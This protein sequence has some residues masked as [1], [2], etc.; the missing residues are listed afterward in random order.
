MLNL[1]YGFPSASS[2]L[3]SIICPISDIQVGHPILN[4]R[5]PDAGHDDG[6]LHQVVTAVRLFHGSFRSHSG[7]SSHGRR[8]RTCL[9]K[10]FPPSSS[11]SIPKL[12]Q[13]EQQFFWL[14]IDFSV[15]SL[16]LHRGISFLLQCPRWLLD[17]L[18]L[19]LLPSAAHYPTESHYETAVASILKAA[20]PPASNST[21]FW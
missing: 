7:R 16:S 17:S 3:I 8:R 20:P 15:G 11:S 1:G 10:I 6:Q 9:E 13:A 21:T 18:A 12:L 2:R 5:S 14:K 19:I 4:I